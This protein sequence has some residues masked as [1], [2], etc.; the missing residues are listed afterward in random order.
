M[1]LRRINERWM[2]ELDRSE[3]KI[4]ILEKQIFKS[5]EYILKTTNPG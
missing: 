4:L 3:K 2:K 5:T 1:S